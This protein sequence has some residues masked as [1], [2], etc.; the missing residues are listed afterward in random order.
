MSLVETIDFSK[1]FENFA[2]ERGKLLFEWAE[3]TWRGFLKQIL[4]VMEGDDITDQD[5]AMLCNQLACVHSAQHPNKH[6]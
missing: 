4:Q 1:P 2:E 5:F 3:Q 6:A